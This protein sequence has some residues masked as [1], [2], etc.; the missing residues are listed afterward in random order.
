MGKK[1]KLIAARNDVYT[2]I[3]KRLVPDNEDIYNEICFPLINEFH[4]TDLQYIIQ[5]ALLEYVDNS[6]LPLCEYLTQNSLK[7]FIKSY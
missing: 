3:N 1:G 4:N 7:E 5:K 2:D 6:N